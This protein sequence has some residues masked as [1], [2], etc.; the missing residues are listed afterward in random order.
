MKITDL[1]KKMGDFVLDIPELY[2]EKGITHSFS[3]F[4][5]S[6]KTTLAKLIMGIIKADSG[7]I[8]LEGFRLQD[9]TMTSQRPYL[10]HDTLYENICY[11]LK[12]RNMMSRKKEMEI[13][14]YLDKLGLSSRKHQYAPSLSSGERQ[15]V[16]MIRALIF[17]PELI[18]IDES[19]SN[20]DTES[21][22]IFEDIIRNRQKMGGTCILITHQ[23]AHVYRLCDRVHFFDKGKII[24]SGDKN[25][26]FRSTDNEKIRKYLRN[27]T[28]EVN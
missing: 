28:I 27:Q 21:T 6:G 20:M 14:H 4:N 25:R 2:I 24:E 17:D 8:D 13:D 3:G 10:I 9:I 1:K 18:I 12:L 11:P 15:K 5:G 16:S 19:L 23:M 7:E 26:I 22:E